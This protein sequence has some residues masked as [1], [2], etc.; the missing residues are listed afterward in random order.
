MNKPVMERRFKT[1]NFRPDAF[2]DPAREEQL[3]S[4]LDGR[5]RW[6]DGT[7]RHGKAEAIDRE[8]RAGQGECEV[9]QALG[10]SNDSH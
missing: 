7:L 3:H 9:S 4:L 10:I 1:Q 2:V 5:A 6:P 8:M